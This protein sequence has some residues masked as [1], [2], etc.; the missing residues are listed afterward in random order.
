MHALMHLQDIYLRF[1]L[2]VRGKVPGNT[3]G[4]AMVIQLGIHSGLQAVNQLAESKEIT[5]Q[6]GGTAEK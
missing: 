1:A 3:V 2:R 6:H 5:G 4:A